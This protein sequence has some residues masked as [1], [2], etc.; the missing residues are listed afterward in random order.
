MKKKEHL[1]F[2]LLAEYFK[3]PKDSDYKCEHT[4]LHAYSP[5]GGKA[6]VRATYQIM[7]KN[8]LGKFIEYT[9]L[10]SRAFSNFKKATQYFIKFVEVTEEIID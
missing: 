8:H 7:F 3:L 6:K 10:S 5:S 4:E 1:Q 9:W 2:A